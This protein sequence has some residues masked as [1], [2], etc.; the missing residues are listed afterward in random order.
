MIV[1]NGDYVLDLLLKNAYEHFDQILI[2]EGPVKWFQNLG[3][4]TSTDNTNKI[5]DNFPDP[6]KKIKIIHGQFAEKDEQ[7]N[8][9]MQYLKDDI[10]YLWMHD[11]DEMYHEKDYK[12]IQEFLSSVNPTSISVCSYS[13]FGG[14]DRYIGGFERY[15]FNFYRIFKTYPKCCYTSHRPPEIFMP[16]GTKNVLEKNIIDGY[17]FERA[18]NIQ[19]HHYSYVWPSQ[20]KSKIKYYDAKVAKGKLYPDYYESIWKKWVKEDSVDN[21]IKI[22]LANQG[23]HEWRYEFRGPAFSEAF[24][25]KHPQIIEHNRK[26]LEE[27]LYKEMEIL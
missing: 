7:S 5:L 27:R 1:F 10:D 19:M 16:E 3:Y 6:D 8:A 18:T 9:Y 25:G 23:V 20:V 15:P 2:A 21:K 24:K 26:K 12:N 13:F 17:S 22:E 11:S 4:T 14:L